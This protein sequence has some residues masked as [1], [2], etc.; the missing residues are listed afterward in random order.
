ME[1]LILVL[2]REKLFQEGFNFK[3]L[4]VNDSNVKA[5]SKVI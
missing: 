3:I 1:T 5:T 4:S 2:M